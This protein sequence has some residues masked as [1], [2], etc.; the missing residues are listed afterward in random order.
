MVQILPSSSNSLNLPV[1][2]QRLSQ[3]GAVKWD[4]HALRIDLT[5]ESTSITVFADGR[6][7]IGLADPAAA[8]TLFDRYIG[9]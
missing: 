8:R 1:L 9:S 7:L 6:A 4:E 5:Q 2:A 3:H